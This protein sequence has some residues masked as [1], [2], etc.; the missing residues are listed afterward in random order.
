MP[1]IV[2]NDRLSVGVAEIDGDH[3][4]LLDMLN[5]L[6]EAIREGRSKQRLGKLLDG[7][8]DYTRYHFGR[9]EGMF[10]AGYAE[11][12]QHKSEHDDFVA[13]ITEMRA[14]FV[15]GSATAPS[16]EVINYLKDWLF[17]HILGCDQSLGV[18]LNEVAVRRD[19]NR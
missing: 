13:W 7:L 17:D 3:K 10:G 19:A 6:Y 9:E 4:C 5:D 8:V 2:W 11:S 18:H 16:L 1:F 15:G 14:R 12:I